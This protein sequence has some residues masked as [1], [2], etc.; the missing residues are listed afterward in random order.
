MSAPTAADLLAQL[1]ATRA[2]EVVTGDCTF[3]TCGHPA[4]GHN[5][6]HQP[7]CGGHERVVVAITDDL[8]NPDDKHADRTDDQ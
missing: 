1:R 6:A 2:T 4:T 5:R 7:M 8:G 3:P